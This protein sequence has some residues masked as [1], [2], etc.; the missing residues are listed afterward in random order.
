MSHA[1]S[2]GWLGLLGCAVWGRVS[3]SLM[4]AVLMLPTGPAEAASEQTGL[5]LYAADGADLGSAPSLDTGVAIGIVGVIARVQVQQRFRNPG[6]DWVEGVYV[7]PLP[8]NAAVDRLRMRYGGRLI[9]GE[10]QERQQA[11]QT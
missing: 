8:Q 7:F 1:E 4:L 3:V 6:K 11:R 2:P 10:I 5:R 9:E